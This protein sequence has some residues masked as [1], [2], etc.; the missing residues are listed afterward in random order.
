MAS[1][2]E[3]SV[4]TVRGRWDRTNHPHPVR[5]F[6]RPKAGISALLIGDQNAV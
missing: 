1:G 4:L 2:E 3:L 6:G 5:E